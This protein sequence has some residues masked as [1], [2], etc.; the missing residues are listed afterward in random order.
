MVTMVKSSNEPLQQN[1]FTTYRDPQTGRWVV[2]KSKTFSE[3]FASLDSQESLKSN[4]SE[5]FLT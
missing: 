2:V 1:P 3:R 5:L 4:N